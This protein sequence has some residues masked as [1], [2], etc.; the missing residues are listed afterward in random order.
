MWT[1]DGTDYEDTGAYAKGSLEEWGFL[2]A[3][4]GSMVVDGKQLTQDQACSSYIVCCEMEWSDE[5]EDY[6]YKKGGGLVTVP[7]ACEGPNEPWTTAEMAAY[8]NTYEGT[9]LTNDE[10]GK[11]TAQNF[12]GSNYGMPC[13][14]DEDRDGDTYEWGM[15]S[16]KETCEDPNGVNGDYFDEEML[17]EYPE[18]SS[19]SNFSDARANDFCTSKIYCCGNTVDTNSDYAEIPTALTKQDCAYAEGGSESAVELARAGQS[20]YEACKNIVFWCEGGDENTFYDLE[21]SGLEESETA[22]RVAEDGTVKAFADVCADWF[23]FVVAR[24]DGECMKVDGKVS[25]DGS[26]KYDSDDDG[27]TDEDD[28]TFATL[29]DAA[30]KGEDVSEAMANCQA[31]QAAVEEAESQ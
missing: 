19:Y 22:K 13:C 6:D 11:E 26:I 23:T 16:D 1:E 25:S 29:F 12:C 27:D 9:V 14:I 31:T 7:A 4:I 17:K 30:E 20:A 8:D 5:K 10:K 24:P 3:E 2:S 15:A 18:Y 28:E 21:T